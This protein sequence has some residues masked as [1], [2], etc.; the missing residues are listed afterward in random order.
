MGRTT[1]ETV[2]V[3]L[4]VTSFIPRLTF[5]CHHR[6]AVHFDLA[7]TM[8]RSTQHCIE[9]C[10]ALASIKYSQGIRFSGVGRASVLKGVGWTSLTMV[11]ANIR[12]Q[13]NMFPTSFI[14]LHQMLSTSILGHR[15][16][17]PAALSNDDL[18][19]YRTSFPHFQQALSYTAVKQFLLPKVALLP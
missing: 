18:L 19:F 4:H 7:I 2:E 15:Q 10:Q 1:A 16:A 6:L 17:I 12:L 3:Q 11:C 14:P 13:Y 9:G 8:Y 5:D